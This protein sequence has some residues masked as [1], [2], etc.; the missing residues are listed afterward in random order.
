MSSIRAVGNITQTRI[1]IYYEY[2]ELPEG[3]IMRRLVTTH[4]EL[5]TS[6]RRHKMFRLLA[7]FK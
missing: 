5:N 3:V 1:F 6:D 7:L 4:R 2:M